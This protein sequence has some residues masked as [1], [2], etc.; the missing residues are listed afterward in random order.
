MKRKYFSNLGV[1]LALMFFLTACGEKKADVDA[2]KEKASAE[3]AAKEKEALETSIDA[4]IFAYPL[5]TMEYTRRALTNTAAPEETKAPMGQ[6]VRLR[7]YPN[8]WF[9]D[10][11]APTRTRSTRRHGSTCPR[12]RGW[13][14]CRT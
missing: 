2:T 11:T 9:K 1:V 3:S 13:L 7:E 4:Y 5:V 12:S 8:A 10:V 6:F 14:A